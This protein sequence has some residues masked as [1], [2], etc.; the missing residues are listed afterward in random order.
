MKIGLLTKLKGLSSMIPFR[1]SNFCHVTYNCKLTVK[2][3]TLKWG[4]DNERATSS[5]RYFLEAINPRTYKGGG[6][7]G[8]V[9]TLPKVFLVFFLDDKSSALEVFYGYSFILRVIFVM[10]SYYGYEK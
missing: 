3:F 5:V 10:V 7:G 6:V 2:V 9:A 1:S 4:N 8:L